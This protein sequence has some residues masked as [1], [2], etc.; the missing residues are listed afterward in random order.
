MKKELNIRSFDVGNRLDIFLSDKIEYTRSQIKNYIKNGNI[1]VNGK[2]EK[3]G[4]LLKE[5]DF[6]YVNIED[7]NNTLKGE[8]IPLNIK[9]E[10]EDLLVISKD[11]NMVVHPGA[12]NSN[13]TLV[14]ALIYRYP[15]IVNVGDEER[16]G[17]VHRLDK[18]TSGLMMV[19][20]TQRAY[21]SLVNQFKD[22]LVEKKYLAIVEGKIESEIYIDEPIGRDQRNRIKFTVTNINSK[23]ARTLL[24]PIKIFDNYTLVDIKLET[25]RTHQIRVHMRYIG[26]P[27]LGDLIY[28]NK[29]KFKIDKQMLHSY[30]LTF[31]HPFTNQKIKIIDDFP[32]RFE[33]FLNRFK[34]F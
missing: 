24:K 10:D 16:P 18:D 11:Q 23:E 6:I 15:Q 17:I 14:N 4:Y 9:Y 2:K 20:K 3:A 26:H 29:N 7:E 13:N 28:G 5:N 21:E 30:S 8:D 33:N 12:G 31:K 22:S 1:L 32:E 34:S 19:A 27:I 25:G